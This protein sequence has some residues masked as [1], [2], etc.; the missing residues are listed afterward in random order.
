MG[1]LPARSVGVRLIWG[2]SPAYCGGLSQKTVLC[3]AESPLQGVLGRLLHPP[4]L[5][6]P[7]LF[8]VFHKTL[9]YVLLSAPVIYLSS[10]HASCEAK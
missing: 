7:G 8:S 2:L 5:H 6:S 4:F 9:H 3:I 10:Q 1:G